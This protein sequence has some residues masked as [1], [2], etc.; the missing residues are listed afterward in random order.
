MHEVNRIFTCMG[1]M[2]VTRRDQTALPYLIWS[3]DAR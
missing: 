2:E 3:I 1:P